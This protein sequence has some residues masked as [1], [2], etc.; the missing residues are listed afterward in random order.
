MIQSGTG[1]YH[2]TY[3]ENGVQVWP[4]HYGLT[5]RGPYGAN[6]ALMHG[7]LHSET[8]VLISANQA[9]CP[10]CGTSWKVGRLEGTDV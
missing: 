4:R 8:L 9:I 1:N 6:D 10:I 7:C 2:C 5:N 3:Y